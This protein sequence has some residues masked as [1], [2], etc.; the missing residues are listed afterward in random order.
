MSAFDR[1]RILVADDQPDVLE[2]L[3]VQAT[4]VLN[5][6]SVAAAKLLLEFAERSAKDEAPKTQARDLSSEELVA[7][8]LDVL[9]KHLAS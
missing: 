7:A 3:Y 2:A 9:Q 8:A 4:D 1:T 5:N 6:R